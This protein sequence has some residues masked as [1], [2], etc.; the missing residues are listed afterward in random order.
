[1]FGDS[2]LKTGLAIC[3]IV[4]VAAAFAYHVSHKPMDFRVYYY[5]ARGVFDGTQPVYGPTSGIGW[6]MHYR[7]PPLFLLL[8]APLAM[9]PLGLAA[10][11]WVVA[12]IAV[13]LC[14][15]QAIKK[16]VPESA[17]LISV[18]FIAPYLIEEFRYGNAQFFVL[19]LTIG[20]LLLLRERPALAAASLGLA[21]SIKVWPLFFIPYLS[22]RR[23][24]KTVAHTLGFAVFLTLLP[25]LYF[26]LSGNFDLLKQ[27]FAQ[28]SQT[29]LSKS[30]IWF[31]NQSVRGVMMRYL[32]VI[33]YSVVPDSN[34]AHINIAT[35]DPAKV[36]LLWVI[37]AGTIYA[38]FLFLAHRRRKNDGWLDHG[39]AFCLLPLLEPFTQKYALAVLL[40][41][42]IAAAGLM[43]N[44][45]IRVLM[46]SATVL[47][48]IQPLVPGAT[49]QRLLQVLGLDF[50]ATMLLTIALGTA[51]L[52]L[53][54]KIC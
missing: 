16:R 29:Q 37:V 35:I 11:L 7:Y 24:W 38:A 50:A 12:K 21:I 30:E 17:F 8:F 3:G 4:A 26:G 27:W 25:A 20:G 18:L 51:C 39:L 2:R 48:M 34:Y 43:N 19:A 31:P 41:P 23:E 32:T 9:L 5:G 47:V 13:L 22:V 28:E 33:D 45:P 54:R 42:A 40:W 44:R 53:G 6:P 14:L 1:M 10:A 36:R 46:Y 15:V 49:A 52:N